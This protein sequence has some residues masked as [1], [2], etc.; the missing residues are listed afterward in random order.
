MPIRKIC[1]CEGIN[2]PTMY[3]PVRIIPN[4]V[5]YKSVGFKL[6]RIASPPINDANKN[7]IGKKALPPN[8]SL[9]AML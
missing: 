4:V 2:M 8:I 7:K 6:G 1:L 5:K 3:I 9:T